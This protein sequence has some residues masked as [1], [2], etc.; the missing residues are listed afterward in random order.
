MTQEFA[1]DRFGAALLLGFD[2]QEERAIQELRALL[3]DTI[4]EEER[5]WI[6]VYEAR[7]LGHLL[8]LAEARERYAEVRRLWTS[9]PEH[10][11][12][13]AVG[14]ATLYEAEGNP[15]RTL[16]ELSRI[17][18]EYT[19]QWHLP[20]LQ[21]P[22]EEIQA[23]RGRLLV[24]QNRWQEALPLLEETLRSE[25]GKPAVLLQPRI[26]LLHG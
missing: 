21:E 18:N 5:G 9:T 8:Q 17:L 11:S 26:L 25:K 20:E 6:I 13:I 22:Y 24:G 4:G 15:G 23:T 3:A 19:G 10:N 14:E 12:R 7:F 2:N 16:D 1:G